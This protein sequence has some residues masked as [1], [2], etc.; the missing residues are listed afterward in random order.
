MNPNQKI[1]TIGSISI[2]IGIISLMLQIGNIISIWASHSIQTGSQ[3]NTGICNQRIITYENSTWVNHTYVNINNTNVVAGEDKTSVTLAGNSS[4]C[5]ISGWAIYTK[6]NSIRIGSKGDVF[7][8]RE[9]FISCSHL[10][11]SN[12][13][14]DP[15]RSI[16]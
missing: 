13:F 15:R 3:N 10:E 2:A 16:K 12:L 5:S 1:I 6:D 14:S 4:L 9:P 11:C 7:V 8:I